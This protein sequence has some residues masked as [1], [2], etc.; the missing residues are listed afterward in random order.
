[1]KYL[2]PL[3]FP[4]V[5]YADTTGNLITNGTFDNGNTGWTTSG[6]AQVIGDCCPG[7]HD[8]EF[9]DNGSITQD[10]NL[11]SDTIT[12]PMLDNGITLNS[13][14]EWQ[15][16][17]GGEGGW[18]GNNRG[19]ADSFT[20]RLQIKDEFGNVLA[21]TTQTRTDVTGIN[22]VDFT[23]TLTYTGI[24]SNIGNIYLSGQD[25]NAPANLGGPNVDN[26]SVTMTYDPIILSLQEV[27][28]I[29]SIVEVVEEL[30]IEEIIIVEAPVIE[31]TITVEEPI[32][33]EIILTAQQ[34]NEIAEIFE[35]IEE[36]FTQEEF[37]QIEELVFEEI[38]LEPIALEEVPIKILEE[39]PM[40]TVEEQFVEET[41][42]LAPVM[43]EEEILETSIETFEPVEILEQ[44][45]IQ[46]TMIEP[47][48]IE[49][50][51]IVEEVF[52]EIVEA[53]VEETPTEEITEETVMAEEPIEET[54][55]V[56]EAPTEEIVTE[57]SVEEP[58]EE[59]NETEVVEETERDTD[60]NESNGDIV[61]E[62]REVDN[63]SRSLE[64]ELTVEEISIKVADKIKTID[65]QLKA[66]QMIVAKVMARDNKI[67]S[68][69]QVNTD[70]FIQPEL[71]SIDIGTY[72]NNTYVDIRNI[73]PNQ[74][75]EDKL[76]TSRQ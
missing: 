69:S 46:S 24:G 55:E 30:I 66:T 17:E 63:E 48:I 76:W 59:V 64:T 60:T 33:E 61:A 27:E 75:Y 21:T 12:Q 53:P 67:A 10:F 58:V 32:I 39:M 71:Q 4:L 51:S 7:G 31:E 5:V 62:E 50:Q 29:N 14:T 8:F 54:I 70:I 43:M 57:Q 26:I 3:L 73:Y 41:I 47:E 25:A 74:T 13:T 34:S 45:P 40:L 35:E 72:T 2:I 22:G 16:G 15:N 20:V 28:H 56:A 6:D 18:A 11:Y 36:V 38:F 9:G 37:T 42:V 68:Y 19:G 49:E 1:M 52:E 44:S 65:G 23:D